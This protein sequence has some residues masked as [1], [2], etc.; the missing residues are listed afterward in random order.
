[1]RNYLRYAGVLN[2]PKVKNFRLLFE[3]KMRERGKDWFPFSAEQY[4]F[5]DESTRLFFMKAR[6]FGVTV[7]GYLRY[8]NVKASMDIRLFGITQVL[9]IMDRPYLKIRS[10]KYFGA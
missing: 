3:G 10:P 2:K 6:M 8:S 7:P 1:M 9:D 4:N 5:F